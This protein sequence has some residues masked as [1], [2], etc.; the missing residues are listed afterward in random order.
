MNQ[1]INFL[2]NNDTHSF[3]DKDGSLRTLRGE[4]FTIQAWPLNP[5]WRYGTRNDPL[6]QKTSE[7]VFN[8]ISIKTSSLF[9]VNKSDSSP[10]INFVNFKDTPEDFYLPSRPLAYITKAEGLPVLSHYDKTLYDKFNFVFHHQDFSQ[11]ENLSQ[12]YRIRRK[13]RDWSGFSEVADP[14]YLASS[15]PINFDEITLPDLDYFTCFDLVSPCSGPKQEISLKT[16]KKSKF[17][18]PDG[19]FIPINIPIKIFSI[20]ENAYIEALLFTFA[21]HLPLDKQLKYNK[22]R[23][24]LL[25]FLKYSY[26]FSGSY[27][28][29]KEYYNTSLRQ[30]LSEA[31]KGYG[32][33]LERAK[34]FAE[35]NFTEEHIPRIKSLIDSLAPIPKEE[36]IAKTKKI[37]YPTSFLQKK[38]K[39]LARLDK[40]T[41]FFTQPSED[42][43]SYSI[44]RIL[45]IDKMLLRLESEK[46]SLLEKKKGFPLKLE[47]LF[48]TLNNDRKRY[49]ALSNQKEALFLEEKQLQK[50]LVAEEDLTLSN[51][52]SNID[53]QEVVF[54]NTT[55]NKEITWRVS[56]G[57]EAS[58]SEMLDE[59]FLS[60]NKIIKV[61]FETKAPSKITLVEKP[62]S[63]VG[64]P[65]VVKCTA[66]N[67][68]LKLASVASYYGKTDAQYLCHPHTSS[69]G[70]FDNMF[71][72]F[73]SACLGEASGIIFKA[74]ESNSL[75]NILVSI[76]LWLTSCNSSDVWGK[77][78]TC[79][80]RWSVYES[81]QN[82]DE[83]NDPEN[84]LKNPDPLLF[85]FPKEAIALTQEDEADN[86]SSSLDP[87]LK[88]PA[89]K[90]QP[91]NTGDYTPFSSLG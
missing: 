41:S 57:E 10:E 31:T 12:F 58:F 85:S 64:G 62:I 32:L 86:S 50:T 35:M 73:R 15:L 42:D 29:D 54:Q 47:S 1:K 70:N 20:E 52:M 2:I 51:F 9:S 26:S 59:T 82:I 84:Y 71:S 24:Y 87:D 36:I 30:S 4:F 6:G 40:I 75:K 45:I 3:L 76:N 37:S 88:S 5:H 7:K 66:S 34:T 79:F 60:Q 44:D 49:K 83:M 14:F 55:S 68:M 8:K 72:S 61:Q 22:S 65:Y 39:T 77:R 81:S 78:Y 43:I 18:K 23:K 13:T 63:L 48:S 16:M 69:I 28:Y 80:K 46:F 53:V 90:E 27:F 67:L 38:E 11:Y 89:L 56:K 74:F 19:K 33:S 25:S 91:T 21:F 17:V